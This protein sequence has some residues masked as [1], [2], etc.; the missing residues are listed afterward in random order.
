[1]TPGLKRSRASCA[2]ASRDGSMA[3][4]VPNSRQAASLE[5]GA[6]LRSDGFVSVVDS[7]SGEEVGIRS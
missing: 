3:S 7:A 2:A 6:A 1:M 5:I 4:S